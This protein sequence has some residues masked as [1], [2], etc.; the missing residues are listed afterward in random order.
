MDGQV[1]GGKRR[2]RSSRSSL[3]LISTSSLSRYHP[4]LALAAG[5]VAPAVLM[6]SPP[7]AHAQALFTY[8]SQP[9][10]KTGGD[11]AAC[12]SGPFTMTGVI[13]SW[14]PDTGDASGTYTFDGNLRL[15]S[16]N[17]GL[18]APNGTVTLG[19][20]DG[21]SLPGLFNA[22]LA[23][24]T[25]CT[26]GANSDAA[27]NLPVGIDLCNYVSSGPGTWSGYRSAQVYGGCTPTAKPGQLD[28]GDPIRITS[29]NLF[30]DVDDYST[31]GVNPLAFTRYYDSFPIP[32]GVDTMFG[33]TGWRSNYDR[34]I[35][36]SNPSS[37]DVTVE[38]PDGQAVFFE[39]SG[40]TY[41]PDSDIPVTLTTSGTSVLTYTLTL[42]DD[43][44]ETYVTYTADAAHLT[45]IKAR[46]G[47]TQTLAY[48]GSNQLTTITDSFSRTLTFSYY[49]SG[50][51]GCLKTVT[52]PDGL[53]TTYQYD[54]S[55]RLMTV[56]YP[57]SPT[58]NQQYVY[59]NTTY[60]NALTGI[61][62]E[63]GNRHATWTYDGFGRATSSQLGGGA[64]LTTV[65]YDDSQALGVPTITNPLGIQ[66][67]YGFTYTQDVPKQSTRNRVA[68]GSILAA[69]QTYTYDGNGYI[70]SRTDWDGNLTSYTNN[71][72]GF[73]TK[74][75]EASGSGVAR[76][77]SIT[78]DSTFHLPDEIDTALNKTTY[79]YDG[80][81]NTT[82][83]T[84]IDQTLHSPTRVYT[85]TWDSLGHKL[86]ETDPLGHITSYGYTG[87]NLVTLTNALGQVTT[88]SN[89]NGRGQPQAITDPNGV[90]TSF[91]Y[92]GRGRT[93]TR[94]VSPT[95]G[96]AV[97]SYAYDGVGDLT[98]LTLAD[99][100]YLTYAYDT[101]HRQIAMH[102]S[103]G[104]TTSY[105]LD[106]MGNVTTLQI[107]DPS[108]TLQ[109]TQSMAYDAIGRLASMT[110][111]SG[112]I[113][114]YGYDSQSNRTSIQDALSNVTTQGYDALNRLITV[115]D[116]LS[117]IT[118]TTYDVL[119]S[120]TAATD[121]RGLITT[122]TRDGFGQVIVENS[123]DHGITTYAYDAAGNVG[124]MQN[125]ARLPIHLYL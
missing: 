107:T 83:R 19:C 43:S 52:A 61:I 120:V 72:Q 93:L 123:P 68:S 64:N 113:T 88:Y 54:S 101:A 53:V 6:V 69:T 76:T 13:S 86:S 25:G 36:L 66:D 89:Y 82:G 94:V 100:T 32:D 103:A 80:S 41:T 75:V 105:T 71:S 2:T 104:D 124:T 29:G 20:L 99:G 45:S 12:P 46:D 4:T 11:P 9:M 22:Y 35:D 8:T 24:G 27:N 65:T 5:I 18:F 73:P 92:D 1:M 111:A 106:A 70:G 67:T 39:M 117:N 63:N 38:R 16:G 102:D 112:G 60:P 55:N 40:S 109:K 50:C 10:N 28:C 21:G 85:Y 122:Y 90:V 95:G 98:T 116:P 96:D 84:I 110:M 23:T 114:T 58:T 87:N 34:Y 33:S 48:N 97:T 125:A 26:A 44:V 77:T 115:K 51:T 121:P 81:G 42:P 74:I 118:T 3:T 37:D 119:D 30:E 79:S 56:T 78:W 31:V 17:G 59:E 15:I 57:T 49:S 47:Y 14:D 108:G 62:D 91:T 7:E